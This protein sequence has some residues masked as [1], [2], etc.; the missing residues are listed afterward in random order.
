[1]ADDKSKRDTR[2]R[3]RV[4]ASDEYEVS[5]FASK[6]NL[7]TDQ[8][9][10]LIKQYGNDRD[11]LERHAGAIKQENEARARAAADR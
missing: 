1:M 11:T 2:D 3:S 8:V 6:F 10:D 4:S 5:Y 7:S 9:L